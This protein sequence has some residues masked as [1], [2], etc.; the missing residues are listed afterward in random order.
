MHGN[1]L[2]DTNPTPEVLTNDAY[3]LFPIDSSRIYVSAFSLGNILHDN[4]TN[5]KVE[6]IWR[7]GFEDREC[8]GSLVVNSAELEMGFC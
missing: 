5:Y 6:R 8:S 7:W 1:L 3:P 4:L 2:Y